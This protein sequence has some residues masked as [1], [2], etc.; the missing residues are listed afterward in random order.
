MQN[1]TCGNGWSRSF[2][3]APDD[4]VH[5]AP[6]QQ[7]DSLTKG[8][9]VTSLWIVDVNCIDTASFLSSKRPYFNLD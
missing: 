6:I 4:G 9:S 3:I 7:G 1:A 8:A 2:F 5:S